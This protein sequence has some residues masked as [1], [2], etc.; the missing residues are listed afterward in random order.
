LLE[1]EVGEFGVDDVVV[2]VLGWVGVTFDDDVVVGWVG[3]TFDD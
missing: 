1:T 3:V 2:V